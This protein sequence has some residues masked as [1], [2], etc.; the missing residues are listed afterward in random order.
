M[1]TS[2]DKI[3]VSIELATIGEPEL[4]TSIS[5]EHEKLDKVNNATE[6]LQL[7][8]DSMMVQSYLDCLECGS[9]GKSCFND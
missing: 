5:I 6:S 9:Y 8:S 3:R 1:V 2:D 7:P 4:I